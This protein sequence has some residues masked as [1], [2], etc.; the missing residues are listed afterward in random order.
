[1][2]A[3]STRDMQTDIRE[4]DVDKKEGS[5]ALIA[6]AHEAS[7]FSEVYVYSH[8][9]RLWRPHKEECLLLVGRGAQ[10]PFRFHLDGPPSFVFFFLQ[11]AGFNAIKIEI[12]SSTTVCT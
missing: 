4:R 2:G 8:F 11:R 5:D 1:M 3:H 9:H 10:R 6:E 7:V 12:M